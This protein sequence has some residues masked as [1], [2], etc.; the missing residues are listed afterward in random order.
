MFGI[1]KTDS[2]PPY[3][4]MD[5]QARNPGYSSVPQ[6]D[7]ADEE[8]PQHQHAYMSQPSCRLSPLPP[9]ST[10]QP[11]THCEACDGF[12]ERQQRRRSKNC[13]HVLVAGTMISAMIC[14]LLLG[15]VIAH[16]KRDADKCRLQGQC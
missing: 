13:C 5:N 12:L 3:Q 4:E 14:L 2:A 8:Q 10:F 16:A 7:I 15:V 6:N 11:H 1:T 9:P